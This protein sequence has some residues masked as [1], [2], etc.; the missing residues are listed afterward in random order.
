MSWQARRFDAARARQGTLEREF[1]ADG[2]LSA[3]RDFSV[4]SLANEWRWTT[5]RATEWRAGWT[6]ADHSANYRAA[7][8]A[9]YGPLARPVQATASTSRVL[10]VVE[11]GGSRHAYVSASRALGERVTATA[12]LRHDDQDIGEVRAGAWSARA[13]VQWRAS[14]HWTLDLDV[15]RYSQQQFLHEVQIDDGL[16][17][18]HPPQHADQLNVGLQWDAGGGLRLRADAFARRIADP[19]TRFD[20]LYNRL[21]LLPELHGD[22]Y[23]IASDEARTRGAEFAAIRSAGDLSWSLSYT[24]SI[25][26]ERVGGV[27][28]PRS[29]DQPHAFKSGLAWNGRAWRIGAF[30]TWRSG[31][32]V[33]PPVTDPAQLPSR[34]NGDRLPAYAS[35]D[36]NVRRVHETAR[37]IFEVYLDVTNLTNRN[38]V[39]GYLYRDD[40]AREGARSLPIVPSLGLTW[41]WR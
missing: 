18:L 6:L 32:P 25:A 11:S 26:E 36:V 30:A 3:M 19:W 2:R 14:E 7:F 20:N 38:N 9:A 28:R 35:V 12:G 29:W 31:W 41:R 39:S 13:A 33:T 1:D 22:R 24:F 17:Q 27:W 16:T 8:D 15:G 37:G 21:V 4:A 23:R 40:F 5:G 34:L 10:S